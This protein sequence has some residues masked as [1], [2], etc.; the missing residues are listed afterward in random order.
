MPKMNLVSN[1]GKRVSFTFTDDIVGRT[2]FDLI[3]KRERNIRPSHGSFNMFADAGAIE[4]KLKDKVKQVSSYGIAM[5]KIPN[6]LDRDTLNRIHEDFHVVEEVYHSEKNL[7]DDDRDKAI[8]TLLKDV[9]F[10]VHELENA[11]FGTREAAFTVFYIGEYNVSDRVVLNSEIRKLFVS[12]TLPHRVTL[13]V[14]YATIGKNLLHAVADNDVELVKNGN[15]RPQL[16]MSTETIWHWNPVGMINKNKEYAEQRDKKMRES[17]DKAVREFVIN[18]NLQDYVG[19]KDP[20]HYN[21]VQPCYAYA[22]DELSLDEWHDIIVN[23]KLKEVELYE[24]N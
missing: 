23:D 13:H 8:R 17:W 12:K 24:D 10:L 6:R 21:S 19:W 5:P 14:G 4:A 2:M 11:L 1:S 18:N 16:S 3:K 22:N 20:I 9:N 7:D 15:L